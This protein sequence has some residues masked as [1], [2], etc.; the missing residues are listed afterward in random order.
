[1][2]LRT[3]GRH[4]G[5]GFKNIGRNSMMTV[6]SVGAVSVSLFILGVFLLLAMNVSY[7]ADKIEEQVEIR[8][9]VEELATEGEIEDVD[10]A[11]RA[12]PDVKEI[13]FVSKEEGLEILKADLGK[14]AGVLEGLEDENPLRD[15][16]Y[17]K[18]FTPRQ[19]SY[20]VKS[21]EEIPFVAEVKYGKETVEDLFKTTTVIKNVGLFFSIGLAVTSLF[22]IANTIRLTIYARRREIEIMKLCGATNWFIR[23]PFFVE[24]VILGILGSVLPILGITLG[25]WKLLES[26][27]HVFF[28]IE[29]MPL[30]PHITNLAKMLVTTG[31]L[32]GVMGS[33]MSVRRYLNV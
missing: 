19:I 11:I 16:F 2:K 33:V 1:M 23:W 32:I 9:F 31:V 17:V 12:L 26:Q 4:I 20:L 3:I 22:L 25:Y 29:M 10:T 8:V 21:I 15:A 14:E 7:M 6:A 27:S 30:L 13:V 5:E 24:G 18:S 28:F